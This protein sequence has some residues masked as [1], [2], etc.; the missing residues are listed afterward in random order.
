MTEV[1]IMV[2]EASCEARAATGSG[3]LA[4]QAGVNAVA[5]DLGTRLVRIEDA[6][7]GAAVAHLRSA[8]EDEVD[9]CD[10]LR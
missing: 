6:G 9:D 10:V 5:A 3:G 2:P 7:G 1:R 8:V 4:V